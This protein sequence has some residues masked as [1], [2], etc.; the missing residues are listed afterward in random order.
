M[1]PADSFVF[2]RDHARRDAI[3]Q[4]YRRTGGLHSVFDSKADIF[5]FHELPVSAVGQLLEERFM[6]PQDRQNAAPTAGE[7]FAFLKRHPQVKAHGYAVGIQREDY[8]VT[9]E[10]VSYRGP[11][12]EALR[13][14]VENMF[15]A[16]D[17]CHVD[18]DGIYVWFD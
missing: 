2:N 5:V 7:F 10:G 9:I 11:V 6:D 18:M 17:E 1:Q 3:L 14:E 4:P 12:S 16:A 13:R 15:A 8:R